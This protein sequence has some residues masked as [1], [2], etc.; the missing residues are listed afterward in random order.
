MVN[1]EDQ[2]ELRPSNGRTK[3]TADWWEKQKDRTGRRTSGRISKP[4]FAPPALEPSKVELQIRQGDKPT[5][6]H[7]V[8]TKLPPGA[9]RVKNNNGNN[10]LK[11][12]QHCVSPNKNSVNNNYNHTRNHL[13][14]LI[15]NLALDV[16]KEQLQEHFRKTGGV[17]S[18][19]IPKEKGQN[20]GK[21]IAYM[22]FKSRISHGIALR[23]HQTTL[24]GKPISVEFCQNSKK[25]K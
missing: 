9:K 23:L 11:A 24:G 8:K 21:G 3:R 1:M 22:D 6:L 18:I 20:I 12:K 5:V 10:P 4:T 7:I 16:T 13:Q 25:S 17:K 14:V 15:K 2:T 19:Q